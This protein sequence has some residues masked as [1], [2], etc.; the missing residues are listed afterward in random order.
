[1]SRVAST[2]HSDLARVRLFLRFGSQP[3]A[4]SLVGLI[5]TVSSISA[6]V[7]IYRTPTLHNAFGFICVSH[8]LADAGVLIVFSFWIAPVALLGF[9]ETISQS[10]FARRMGQLCTIFWNASI[11]GQLQIAINRFLAITSPMLYK[12]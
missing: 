11:Y 1:M 2:G 8:L 6:I 7:L 4:L 12:C 9:S 5:G 10:Y 3:G